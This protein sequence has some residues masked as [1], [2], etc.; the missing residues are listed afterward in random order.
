MDSRELIEP[1]ERLLD[2]AAPLATLRATEAGAPADSLWEA[3]TESG[4]L[5]ALVPEAAG[6]AGLDLA[7]LAPLVES[8]GARLV[9]L[10]V[11]QTMVARALLA[12]NGA[13]PPETPILL[14]SP[15]RRDNGWHQNLASE[16][17]G[18]GHALVDLG[19]RAILVAL[20]TAGV[21]PTGLHA[22]LSARIAWD[23]LP[24]ALAEIPSPAGGLQPIA[25]VLRALEIAGAANRM[26]E[27][28]AGYASERIQFGKP[29]A[30][31]QA[32]QQQL[33]VMAEQALMARMAGRI[34][35]AGGLP[36]SAAAAATAK[37]VASAAVPVVTATA[38]A[39]HGAIG[40]SEEYDLQL[41]TRRLYEWRMADGAESFW[42]RRLGG[43]RLADPAATSVAFVRTAAGG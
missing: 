33:A 12:A 3:I 43:L 1:F 27:M 38:H 7:T 30:K 42:A 29:I 14:L 39:V 26:V 24:P 36:P 18:A 5:D 41:F 34:G 13:Q 28:T 35:A 6:G 16:A 23:G 8:L 9:P 22:S 10:P 15:T 31:F 11:A 37:Q 25:A 2:D 40:F 32:I 4:F 20:D 21:A 19:D 17:L